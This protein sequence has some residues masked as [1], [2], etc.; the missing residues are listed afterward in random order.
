MKV[1]IIGA[2]EV[3]FHL[4]ERLSEENQDVVVIESDPDRAEETSDQLDVMTIVGNGASLPVLER[5][6]VRGA[7]ILMA[8]T[9][10][11]EVNLIACLAAGRMGVGYTIAR[12]S[13]PE[14]H[15]SGSVLSQDTLG[16]DLM[17]NPA[18][19]SAWET[20]HLLRS[21]AATD[22]A[23][24]AEGR[25]QLLG[26]LVK[27]GAP[28]AGRTLAE[29][30]RE[31]EGTHYLLTAILRDGETIIPTGATRIEAGD[32]VYL[33][34]LTTEAHLIPPLAGYEE[35][36][37]KR[38]MIAGGS[39]EG[40][41][42]AE[43]LAQYHI[44]ATI[45]ERDRKRCLELAEALPKALVLNGDVTDLELLELEGVAGMDGYLAATSSDDTNMLSS[46]IA[47]QA[48]A[49]KVV[50]L[51]SEFDYLPLAPKVGIDAAVSPRISAVN[52][53]LRYVRRGRVTS[54][55]TLKGI[56]A[57]TIQFSVTQDSQVAGKALKDLA[58]PKGSLIG[59]I[60]RGDDLMIPRGASV[61]LPGDEV[62]VFALPDA[63]SE[64]ERA[65]E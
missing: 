55:A 52:A 44:E 26:L 10:K 19:E 56:D 34:S 11:D 43:I 65:F 38:V 40:A 45:I 28:V 2:G 15:S 27:E 23:S 42:L 62:I 14:Y 18:R 20:F 49:K 31:L 37:V 64:I 21:P 53:I 57:E 58:L 63:I 9:S 47:K 61:I 22:V 46:L 17:I 30:G 16:I 25:L 6:G 13:N 33:L 5:A 4:A 7:N 24:F 32:Q 36:R 54:V 8:V 39:P 35:Y 1:L 51:I 12:V 59:S 3:G 29:L 60:I 41:Y 48:G 50:S